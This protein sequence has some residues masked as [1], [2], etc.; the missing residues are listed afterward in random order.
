MRILLTAVVALPLVAAAASADRAPNPIFEGAA[1][2]VQNKIDELVFARLAKAGIAPARLASDA[3]FLR[4]AY[5]DVIGTLPTVEETRQFLADADPGKRAALIHRLL[6]RPEFHDY[7]AMKWCDLLRVKA[8]F[9]I[10]LWPNAAQA[11]QGWIRASVAANKPYDQLARELL[12]ASGSNFRAGEVNFYRAMQNREPRGIAQTVALTF[13]G[14]RAEKWPTARLDGMTVFFSQIGHK[15]TG[16]WKEEILYFDP[17]KTV[18]GKAV[19]PDGT[20]ANLSPDR[21]PRAVF[22]EWLTAPK[23]PYFARAMANRA[24]NWLLGRGIVHEADDLR[25]DNR[26]ANPELLDYLAA[27]LVKSHYDLKQLYRLILTSATYQLASLP[28]SEKPEAAALFAS[29][30]LR[31]LDAEL[32]IDAICQITGT[33]ESYTSAI[34]EPYTFIPQ[35]QRAMMLPDG[36]ITSPFLELFGRPPRDTGL[37]AERNNR[38]TAAQALHM[39]NSTHLQRKLEQS[40]KM[41]A[42]LRNAANPQAAVSALY[43]LILSRMPSAEELRAVAAYTPAASRNRNRDALLDLAWA[44]LNSTEFQ[45]R[46]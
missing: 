41:Q 25:D 18:K 30:P 34:P 24:W 37:E 42:V 39:L 10:N 9:P 36:S 22:A 19:F 33:T 2:S 16:E 23:N 3:V 12:T 46:H 27:E 7:W 29:Y 4:R 21:D 40:P 26:G 32:L 45:Y 44:L 35:G 31:R 20:A 5:L 8:E 17:A 11:Y 13:L 38:P 6:D 14:M 15:E 1:P 28:S 43:L